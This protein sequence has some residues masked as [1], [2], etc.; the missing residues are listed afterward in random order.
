[1]KRF[2]VFLAFI[3]LFPSLSQ[4]QEAGL[5]P[6]FNPKFRS[7]LPLEVHETSGLFFHNGR[8]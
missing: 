6:L 4:A 5:A 8:L 2:N 1:M 3:L 7:E